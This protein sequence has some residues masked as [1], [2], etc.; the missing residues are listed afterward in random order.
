MIT[1]P[2]LCE[3]LT[4]LPLLPAESN[5]P[6]F[7][8]EQISDNEFLIIYP[9]GEHVETFGSILVRDNKQIH[10]WPPILYKFSSKELFDVYKLINA[11]TV[12][13]EREQALT[14]LTKT[15]QEN[16]EYDF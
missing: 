7:T 8:F 10:W 11:L 3:I 2:D 1:I 5:L 9:K 6:N 15:A 13:V 16:G 14:E 12:L 4:G